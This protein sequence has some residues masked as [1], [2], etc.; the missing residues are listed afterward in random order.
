M[1]KLTLNREALKTTLTYLVDNAHTS[2]LQWYLYD[3]RV[4]GDTAKHCYGQNRVLETIIDELTSPGTFLKIIKK[5]NHMYD[6]KG[7]L[8]LRYILT[9]DK[10]EE[11]LDGKITL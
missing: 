10:I 7:M 6:T 8:Y 3:K 9:D 2:G 1:E 4:H 11:I 5:F